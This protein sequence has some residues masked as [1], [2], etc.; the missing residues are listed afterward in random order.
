LEEAKVLI[1]DVLASGDWIARR[2]IGA[3][4]AG[5]LSDPM[6]GRVKK[7]LDIENRSVRGPN[8]KMRS[9]WRLSKRS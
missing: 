8:G 4:L 2:E 3:K 5:R 6:F 1:A 9:E 7:D